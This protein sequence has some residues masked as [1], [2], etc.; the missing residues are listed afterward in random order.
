MD[1]NKIQNLCF[2][3]MLSALLCVLAPLS[4]PIG[5]AVPIS[6]A[7]FVIYIISGLLEPLYATISVSI[8]VL[9]GAIGLPVFAGYAAGLQNL[10]G[11]T[12]GYIIGYIPMAWLVAFMYKK[13]NKK[14]ILPIAMIIG[15]VVLYTIGTAWFMVQTH[16]TLI[17]SLTICVL[18]F[19]PGDLAKIAASSM[20]VYPV[21]SRL[22]SLNLKKA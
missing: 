10:I 20:L 22:V 18:P 4:I 9:L 15:T 6:M 11:V 7:T 19:I 21:R 14:A 5:T 1:K 16:N 12:G 3:A 8:Y 2:T 13:I 17:Q